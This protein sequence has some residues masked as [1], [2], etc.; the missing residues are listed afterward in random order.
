MYADPSFLEYDA[1]DRQARTAT[2]FHASL[3]IIAVDGNSKFTAR[4]SKVNDPID[5]T[6]TISFA[7]YVTF[8]RERTFAGIEIGDEL[9]GCATQS[10]VSGI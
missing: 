7:T 9:Q 3:T 5:R 4:R 10:H 8:P 1:P 2:N 6:M